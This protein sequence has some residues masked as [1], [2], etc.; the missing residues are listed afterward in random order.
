MLAGST[1]LPFFFFV[2]LFWGSKGHHST[3]VG[4]G[5]KRAAGCKR[6]K[7]WVRLPGHTHRVV[8]CPPVAVSFALR[9]QHILQAACKHGANTRR[10]HG[11]GWMG[12]GQAGTGWMICERVHA[13]QRG[14]CVDNG[15]GVG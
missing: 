14:V 2:T 8:G 10:G 6:W 7:G 3:E 11:E 5:S 13:G 4:R 1:L 15:G 12:Q 9:G